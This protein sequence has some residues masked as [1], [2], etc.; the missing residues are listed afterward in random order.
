MKTMI[1]RKNSVVPQTCDGVKFLMDKNKI[2]IHTG[3]GSFVDKTH[4]KVTGAD[5]KETVLE[6]KNVIIATGSKP[7][8]FP[9]MEPDGK[10]IITSTE[11]LNLDEVCKN[12]I[13][14]GGGVIGLELGSVHARLG[15]KVDVVEFLDSIIPTMDRT[16][17]KELT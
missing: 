2:D 9:G 1:D 11:M 16:L 15:A 13:V 17:G 5:G 4:V 6:T 12:L 10:R 14:I 7:N 3:V 8:Y